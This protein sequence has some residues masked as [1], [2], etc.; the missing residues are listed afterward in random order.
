MQTFGSTVR[1]WK[2]AQSVAYDRTPVQ[3]DRVGIVFLTFFHLPGFGTLSS[4]QRGPI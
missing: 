1:L 3:P 4:N 2:P